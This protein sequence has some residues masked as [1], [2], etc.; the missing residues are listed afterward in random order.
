MRINLFI[1]YFFFINVSQAQIIDN[2]NGTAFTDENFFNSEFIRNNKIKIIRGAISMKREGE[3]MVDKNQF[4]YYEFD[5]LGRLIVMMSTFSSSSY[6]KDT[7]IIRYEYDSRSNLITKRRNDS[8]GFYAY[9]YE[10]DSLNR[11]TKETY[12]REENAGPDRY[13]FVPGR[14]F[15]ISYETFTYQKFSAKQSVKK[16][17]NNYGKQYQEK[18]S[19]Y[20][21][22]GYLKEELM[23]LTLSGKESKV[24][25]EYDEH[26]RISKKSDISYIF[27]Y[28]ETSATFRYDT[29]GNL[30]EHS[31]YQNEK[32]QLF[33][34][35]AYDANMLL[36]L[37]VSKDIATGII[38][39]VKFE[40][41][42]F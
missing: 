36:S 3:G 2:A 39:I 35:L 17:F 6:S 5:N 14:Q 42:F 41:S 24:V 25:Y 4:N 10:Y 15:I 19:Y 34:T 7:M 16:Y 29:F 40:H 32:Q 28:S 23:R 30:L 13:N 21:E 37:E 12:A 31:T 9:Y 8:Y 18:F 1:F 33:R 26:G 27:G 11:L 22:M 20:D 38:Y